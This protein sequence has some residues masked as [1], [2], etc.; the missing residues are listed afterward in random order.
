MGLSFRVLGISEYRGFFT[1]WLIL[2]YDSLKGHN[3][4]RIRLPIEGIMVLSSLQP[5]GGSPKV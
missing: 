5:R 3:K 1:T 2:E 4:Y